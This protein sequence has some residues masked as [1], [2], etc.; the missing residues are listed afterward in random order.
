MMSIPHE[1]ALGSFLRARRARLLPAQVGLSGGSRRRAP[2]LRREEVAELA[3]IST[4]WYV[5]LEQGRCVQPS[6][7]T[8]DA[9]ARA[10]RLNRTEHAHLRSLAQSAIRPPWVYESVPE[11]VRQVVV[12]LDRPA[13]VTGRRW[14][15]LCWNAAAAKVFPEFDR[16]PEAERNILLFMFTHPAARRLFAAA[17]EEEARRM[18][19]LFRPTYDLWA[20]D[21][22]FAGLLERLRRDSREFAR[23]WPAHEVRPARAGHKQLRP[24]KQGTLS[25]AYATFQSNDDPALKLAIYAPA[26]PITS[27]RAPAVRRKLRSS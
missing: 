27:P 16:M 19:A 11:I 23:W 8:L 21:P 18:L 13:Y 15:L 26:P 3:G 4:D 24:P 17:W 7:R 20:H 10:L 22:A 5:R 12:S 9:L 6:A 25:F 2:G 1:N 14:D